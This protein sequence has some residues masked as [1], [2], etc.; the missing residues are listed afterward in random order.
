MQ[1]LC[2]RQNQIT[3][4]EL[5]DTFAPTL[6]ELDLYDNLITHMKGFDAFTELTSLDLSFNKIKHIKRINHLTKLR[7]LFFVQNK[8]ATIAGLDGLSELRQIE[9]GANRIRVRTGTRR[10]EARLTW[11]GN[12]KPRDARRPGAALAGQELG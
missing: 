6:V 1:R 10:R 4:I 3:D 9:L 2:L 5:P 8:I 11:A 7:N 12:P